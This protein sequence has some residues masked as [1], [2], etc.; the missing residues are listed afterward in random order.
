MAVQAETGESAS[1]SGIKQ[2][3]VEAAAPISE[4]RFW[5]S[6]GQVVLILFS[7]WACE[8]TFQTAAGKEEQFQLFA[9]LYEAS[10][11]DRKVGDKN[12][13]FEMTIGKFERHNEHYIT[14][15]YHEYNVN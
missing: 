6:S 12:I 10:M 7:D 4:V 8:I 3:E 9:C 13:Q 15:T 11:I 5:K 14:C 1:D 2:V